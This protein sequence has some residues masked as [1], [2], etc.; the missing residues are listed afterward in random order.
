MKTNNDGSAQEQNILNCI[1]AKHA[2]AIDLTLA[3]IEKDELKNKALRYVIIDVRVSLD[4][5]KNSYFEQE[6][7][8][9]KSVEELGSSINDF[10]NTVNSRIKR[11]NKEIKKAKFLLIRKCALM[12]QRRQ[13][14]KVAVKAEKMAEIYKSLACNIKEIKNYDLSDK[15]I[16]IEE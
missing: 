3:E 5:V 9:I 15:Q 1:V 8:M 12:M 4:E 10:T 14:K 2:A 6:D 7:A 11:R 16:Q 13:L